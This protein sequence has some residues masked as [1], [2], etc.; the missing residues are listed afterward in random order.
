MTPVDFAV[1]GGARHIKAFKKGDR[2]RE[3]IAGYEF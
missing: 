1:I 2:R 3:V